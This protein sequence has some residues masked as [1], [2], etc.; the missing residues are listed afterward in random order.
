MKQIDKDNFNDIPIIDMLQPCIDFKLPAEKKL[1]KKICVKC[2]MDL[3]N[4]HDFIKRCE[5]S[6]VFLENY[7]NK[8]EQEEQEFKS[9]FSADDYH[10][11]NFSSDS[12]SSDN[13]PL[14]NK[15]TPKLGERNTNSATKLKNS[16]R[17]LKCKMKFKYY[18]SLVS[19]VCEPKHLKIAK[20]PK[21]T[22]GYQCSKCNEKFRHLYEL[23]AHRKRVHRKN[24]EKPAKEK[25]LTRCAR[26]DII[27]PTLEELADHRKAEHAQD[28]VVTCPVCSKKMSA[29]AYRSHKEIHCTKLKY[30]CEY[31]GNNY[32]K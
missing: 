12:D 9:S 22:R 8:Q 26:C 2:V 13:E 21:K 11:D 4:V 15:I 24:D 5:N 1:P 18:S 23:A 28:R 32:K 16:N 6:K 20:Q 7:L 3:K 29:K 17:C 19:H 27:F 25:I 14:I 30:C 31:C 10:D